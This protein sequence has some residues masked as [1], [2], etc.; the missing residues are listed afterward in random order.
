MFPARTSG[1]A[2]NTA[3]SRSGDGEPLRLAS[4]YRYDLPATLIATSPAEPA[5]AARL[6][7]VAGE[8]IEHRGF[9]D[10]PSLLRAGDVLV[11]NETRVI[12]ARLHATREPGGGAAEILLLR[13]LD[14]PRFDL[15]ARRW[16]ALVKP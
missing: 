9:A 3:L 1:E 14:R 7:V 5:D 16:E 4:A 8:R 6:M 13:P 12:R 15:A 2:R 11:V 10:L